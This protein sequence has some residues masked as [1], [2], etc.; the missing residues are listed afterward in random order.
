MESVTKY[1][2]LA[3]LIVS[4][5]LISLAG[6]VGIIEGKAFDKA[7]REPLPGVNILLVGA[8]MSKSIEPSL[9]SHYSD[10]AERSGKFSTGN[11]KRSPP[12]Y[13]RHQ[14]QRQTASGGKVGPATVRGWLLFPFR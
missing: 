6:T 4:V 14:T 10:G 11:A 5:Q 8:R 3:S 2:L 7:T 12:H 13:S 1:L 9:Q